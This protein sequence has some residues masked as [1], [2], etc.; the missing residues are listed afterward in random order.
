MIPVNKP[1]FI[2][3]EKDYLI[4]CIETGWIS[5]DG[6]YV[7]E[8]EQ[9]FAKYLGVKHA[10][11]VVNGTVAI[12]L[13]LAALPL[14]EGDEVILPS[15]TIVSCP[16]GII[17]R[18]LKPVLVDADPETWGIDVS[19]IEKKI[20]SRTRAIMPVHM[21]GHS[22][23]MDPI[24]DLAKRHNLFVIED[25]AEVHGATYKGKY[26]GTI[27][28]VAT[29]SFYAN[30]IITTG[31][32][33]M[34]VTNSDDVAEK[35]RYFRNLCFQPQQRFLH[36]DLGY[37]FRMT[38]L[39]AA[40]GVAQ[41]EKFDELLEIKKKQ[42]ELYTA[43]FKDVRQVSLQKVKPWAN[44]VYWVF[45]LLLDKNTKYSA[46]DLAK[47]LLEKGVQ[48]RPFFWSLHEQPVFHKMGL[49]K[50][51]HYPVT[52]NLARKGLYVPSGMALTSD[53]QNQVARIFKEA[54]NEM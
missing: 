30:K 51:E 3:N 22:C 52:E 9:R 5:S 53:E 1:L 25:A 45:G 47:K 8:F 43:L 44:H 29:F 23:D 6:P 10:V 15:H 24:M 12:E 27:G 37:N 19:Q 48:T 40:I 16:M 14:K 35:A 26:C 33:G 42:G 36:E 39:Q 11:A 4:K 7:Q 13:A 41:V 34:V 38:N 54:L 18:G 49:F 17:R 20:T 50:N 2:G 32:G 31:E 28:H 46:A 21:F